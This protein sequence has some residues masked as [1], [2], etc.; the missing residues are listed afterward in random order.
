MIQQCLAMHASFILLFLFFR[1]FSAAAF[2]KTSITRCVLRMRIVSSCAWPETGASTA[3]SRNACLLACREMVRHPDIVLMR[4]LP[5]CSDQPKQQGKVWFERG[6]AAL[7]CRSVWKI[8]GHRASS[9][10]T[11][12]ADLHL[13]CP[14]SVFLHWDNHLA[15][16]P[17]CRVLSVFLLPLASSSH[18]SYL[19]APV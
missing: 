19:H 7:I 8:W 13:H 3:A 10:L 14:S 5:Q 12:S 11:L 2:S 9:S 18:N 4:I 15:L 16:Y 6:T 1:V 17:P